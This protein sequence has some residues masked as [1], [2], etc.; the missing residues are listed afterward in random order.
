MTETN[1]SETN[2]FLNAHRG[3]TD[4]G[5]ETH[6]LTQEE[7]D[8]QIKNYR[9]NFKLEGYITL[10]ANKYFHWKISENSLE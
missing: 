9:S 6:I 7:V 8:E 2:D 1:N 5:S 4:S 3:E 10:F